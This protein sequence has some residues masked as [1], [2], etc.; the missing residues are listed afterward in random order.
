MQEDELVGVRWMPL[1]EYLAIPF[2]ANR[3]LFQKIHATI[4]A[5]VNGTYR[6]RKWSGWQAAVF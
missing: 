3:P 4:R 5:Y 6:W 1:D 2:T